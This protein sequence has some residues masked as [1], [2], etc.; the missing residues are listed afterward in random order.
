MTKAELMSLLDKR[1]SVLN[2][3]ERDD[4]KQDFAMHIDMKMQ[5]GLTEREAVATLGD[6]ETVIEDTLLAYNIDPN[7][8]RN[9]SSDIGQKIRQALNSEFAQK[10]GE[11][12]NKGIDVVHQAVK[13]SSPADIIKA[14]FIIILFCLLGWLLFV[15]G[16]AVFSFIAKVICDI[17]PDFLFI[18]RIL[19]GAVKLFYVIFF[20]AGIGIVIYRYVERSAAKLNLNENYKKEST[21]MNN[22]NDFYG[23]SENAYE[24]P[25]TSS[26]NSTN[27]A[28]KIFD[29]FLFIIKICIFFAVLTMLFVTVGTMMGTGLFLVTTF[30][31]L[32][33]IGLTLICLGVTL[34][35]LS[36]VILVFK[37][38]FGNFTLSENK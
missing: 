38:M 20:M 34:C 25:L 11:T 30:M 35:T 32:P 1:L 16:L 4:I 27:T 24:K 12:F 2:E 3:T 33:T 19:A 21:K 8:D 14:M 6:I 17:L 13:E 36:I 31:G 9:T 29:I 7:Y 37:L 26:T 5:E 22:E 10:T 28:E 15:F 18:D 23:E